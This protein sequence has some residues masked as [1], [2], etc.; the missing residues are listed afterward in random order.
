[1]AH[2]L[3]YTVPY[4]FVDEVGEHASGVG[5]ILLNYR[6]QLLEEVGGTPAIAPRVSLIFASGDD[7]R[8]FGDGVLGYQF[9]LPI[10]RTLTDRFYVNVNAGFTH[11]PNVDLLLSNDRHSRG[12][13]L[14]SFNLGASAIYAVTDTFHLLVEAVWNSDEALEER[15]SVDG[16]RIRAH[17]RRGDDVVISPGVRWA[18]NL[19]GDL[20]IVPGVAFP[21]GLS[22]D[23]IDY[24]VFL[25]L[26]V[27]HPFLD[28]GR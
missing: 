3:S 24:G 22:D 21:I 12:M 16:R 19:P 7:D 4:A 1:M 11:L 15:V 6:Y 13:D 14:L 9:N 28:A 5:D 27:E 2:Q 8:G 10:S 20:Q 17:R 23:A 26:S 18:M 25:Y